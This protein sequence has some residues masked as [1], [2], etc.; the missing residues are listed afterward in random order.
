[1]P[2]YPS[3]PASRGGAPRTVAKLVAVELARLTSYVVIICDY[4]ILQ[5]IAGY[6]GW[7]CKP[8]YN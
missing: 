5:S 1:M 8:S 7:S 3:V 4:K 2:R 6:A